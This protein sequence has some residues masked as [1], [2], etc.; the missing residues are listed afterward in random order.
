MII[1]FNPVFLKKVWGGNKIGKFLGQPVIN[2]CGECWGISTHKNGESTINNGIHKGKTLKYIYK[3]HPELFGFYNG[4]EFPILVKIIDALQDLSIQVH[5]G[6]D[7][8]EQFN[9]S[10]KTECW[11]ILET[12][13][14][15][16]I[17]I[18][19]NFLSKEDLIKNI[20]NENIVNHLNKFKI[21]K[22]DYFY[23]NS[24]TIHAICAGTLLLEVQQSSDITYRVFDYKRL[25]NGQLR[26][27]HIKE[28][29]D[30][31]KIPDSKAIKNH[32]NKY[33]D[34]SIFTNNGKKIYTSHIHG[35]Y[36][37]I[38]KG[39]G[40]IND[41]QLKKGDFLMISSNFEYTIEGNLQIQK[42][43]F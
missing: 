35:D 31:I 20:E 3:N 32:N 10:G 40:M 30:V 9:A 16:D 7:Y 29:I 12:E 1:F 25:D 17:I 36:L 11:Y 37:V 4:K 8:A 39:T 41:Y 14:N 28:A 6:D 5:P 15:T 23:I 19:H 34:Y 26:K 27:L 22:G 33:F 21:S 43:W 38:L 42:T 13:E 2:N 24:G 18:G